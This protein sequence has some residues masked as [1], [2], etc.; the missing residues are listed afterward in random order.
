MTAATPD[1]ARSS[2]GSRDDCRSVSSRESVVHAPDHSANRVADEE[3]VSKSDKRSANRDAIS[4]QDLAE[5]REVNTDLLAAFHQQNHCREEQS[6]A[7]D[8]TDR[9]S[10]RPRVET[11]QRR[12]VLL[13]LIQLLRCHQIWSR[14][15]LVSSSSARLRMRKRD[16]ASVKFRVNAMSHPTMKPTAKAQSAP[17][18][19]YTHLRA[20]ETDSYLV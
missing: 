10:P 1:A 2:T 3:R 20:H 4:R 13:L 8:E 14:K 6:H 17:T 9:N 15:S 11:E 18:V 19:S 12:A 16:T 7:E 5:E